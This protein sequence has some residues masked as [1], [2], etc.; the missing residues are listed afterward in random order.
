MAQKETAP[1]QK[2][3]I[4][5]WLGYGAEDEKLMRNLVIDTLSPKMS[6]TLL[7]NMELY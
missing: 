5:G 1:L 6:R 2:D 3:R 4:I 7:E